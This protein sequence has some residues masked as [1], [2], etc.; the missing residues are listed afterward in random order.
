MYAMKTIIQKILMAVI[1]LT[2][3][4][5]WLLRF[6]Q[7][8]NFRGGTATDMISEFA[9]YGLNPTIMYA[10]GTLKVLAAIALLLGIWYPKFITPALGIISFLML[11]AIY[12]HFSIH[13]DWIKSVPAASLLTGSVLLL[14]MQRRIRPA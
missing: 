4:N 2:I 12:F 14:Y 3:L 5:V 13:D 8:S 11:S 7:N 9:A 1:A 6:G 10:V